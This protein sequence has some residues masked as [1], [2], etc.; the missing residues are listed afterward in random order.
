[1]SNIRLVT[2][3]T[4]P[5]KDI[6]NKVCNRR[7]F[8]DRK[9]DTHILRMWWRTQKEIE[10]HAWKFSCLP[11]KETRLMHHIKEFS[12]YR[13]QTKKPEP[14][15]AGTIR[16]MQRYLRV[17]PKIVFRKVG[18]KGVYLKRIMRLLSKV[19]NPIFR[20]YLKYVY[21]R[22]SKSIYRNSLNGEQLIRP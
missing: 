15:T 20:D 8:C 19:A 5:W 13:I 12:I 14:V 22:A 21:R 4:H 10:A 18:D 2:T 1:M 16:T 6:C 17:K 11:T 3:F 7:K 9:R